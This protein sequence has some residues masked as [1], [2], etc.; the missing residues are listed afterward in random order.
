[1]ANTL[2]VTEFAEVAIGAAG[3]V[4]PVPMH[5][6]V[7]APYTVATGAAS[8]TF[9]IKTRILR[10]HAQ[11]GGM[12]YVISTAGT[13]AA[14]TDTRLAQNQIEYVGV[15]ATGTYKITAIDN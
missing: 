11:T 14:I 4:A 8:T 7:V 3:R 12:S 5:P 9:N 15:P 2:F 13:G 6:P 10:L 1:M